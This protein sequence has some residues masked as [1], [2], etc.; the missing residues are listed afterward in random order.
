MS[1]TS[2]ADNFIAG[3]LK[4][5]SGF[6]CGPPCPLR[7]ILLPPHAP[8][9]AHSEITK[10]QTKAESDS[11]ASGL[12]VAR[13]ILCKL[14]AQRDSADSRQRKENKARNFEPQLVQDAPE[15]MQRNPSRLQDRTHGPVLPRVLSGH[16]CKDT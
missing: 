6:L 1:N 12:A 7:L 10:G 15:R 14:P 13:L 11:E 16:L 4:P 8:K 3:A 5:F 2:N 9:R